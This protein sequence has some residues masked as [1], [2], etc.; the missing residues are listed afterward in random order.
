[1]LVWIY[2][3]LSLI[4]VTLASVRI[5][6]K[7][8]QYGFTAL[9]GFYVVYLAASQVIATRVVSFDPGF[10]VLIAP[11][12]VFI[13]PFIAQVIDMIN[14]VYGQTMT[15]VAIGIAFISQV[16]LVIFFLMVSALTP[17]PVFAYET[18]WQ[19]IFGMSIRI[20]LASW[21]AFLICSMIDA[22]IFARLKERYLKRE[23]AFRHHTMLNP[24]IWL[25]STASDA[26]SLTLDSAIFVTIAI[27][28][29]MPI[30]PLVIG[31]IVV[32]NIIGFI[33]NPWFV[34][35]KYL[36]KSGDTISRP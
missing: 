36:L 26:V 22:C 18:A 28:G 12:S 9:T 6:K 24:Y 27:I 23:Q 19:E 4:L 32:K 11:A 35:Y 34:W 33:D 5:V 15:H 17:A 13:Y 29:V 25:R 2:W 31:Q 21:V 14:E 16:L 8:P 20:T 10:Y 30:L 7:Y 1:M 3:V